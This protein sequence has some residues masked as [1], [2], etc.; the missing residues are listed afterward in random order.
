V[1][2]AFRIPNFFIHAIHAVYASAY[3]FIS[4]AGALLPGFFNTS[5]VRQG[6]PLSAFL[7]DFC[8]DPILRILGKRLCRAGVV[9]ALY[10]DI[11]MTVY[12]F[13]TYAPAIYLAF[14]TCKRI[15]GFCLNAIKSVFLVFWNL[16]YPHNKG[17]GERLRLLIRGACIKDASLNLGV[18]V[19]PGA[20]A[21][22]W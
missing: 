16:P 7:F 22:A 18:L 10:D 12:S 19:G 6:C 8:M 17:L 11:G 2:Q 14:D 1:L 3:H 4:W 15:S 13:Q 20:H 9:R 5:G 21:N